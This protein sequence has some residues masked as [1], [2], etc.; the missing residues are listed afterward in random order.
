MP[1]HVPPLVQLIVACIAVVISALLAVSRGG[2]RHAVDTELD[3]VA[4]VLGI[5]AFPV[6]RD[7]V[8]GAEKVRALHTEVPR[9]VCTSADGAGHR[10]ASVGLGEIDGRP[11]VRHTPEQTRLVPGRTACAGV[12]EVGL[13]VAHVDALLVHPLGQLVA[14]VPHAVAARETCGTP[15]VQMS[16][17]SLLI[18]H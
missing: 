9:H 13:P 5:S 16:M 8:R 6:G 10:E 4:L 11:N 14:E 15:R 3:C 17:L 18:E 12:E 2:L 7:K 1:S